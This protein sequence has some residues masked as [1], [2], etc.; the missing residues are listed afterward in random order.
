MLNE[1]ELHSLSIEILRMI[2]ERKVPFFSG[3][4]LREQG[5]IEA[6]IL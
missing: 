4:L 2:R 3:M 6:S 1:R 5:A